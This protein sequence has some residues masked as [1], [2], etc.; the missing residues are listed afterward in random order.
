MPDARVTSAHVLVE[1]KSVG[2]L[3]NTSAH[4]LVEQKSRAFLMASSVYLL[5]EEEETT[6]SVISYSSIGDLVFG[7][8][9]IR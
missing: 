8:V 5:V 7:S 9:I 4:V 6:G 3:Y 1:Q 2:V